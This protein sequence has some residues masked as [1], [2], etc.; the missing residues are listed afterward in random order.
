LLRTEGSVVLI[1]DG[2]YGY[3]YGLVC[4]GKDIAFFDVTSAKQLP[5]EK[6][7][8]HP[9]FLRLPVALPSMRRAEWQKIG[10][11]ELTGFH[12]EFAQYR[13]EPVGSSPM[14][15][16][17]ATGL[18]TEAPEDAL[19]GLELMSVWDAEYHIHPILRFHFHGVETPLVDM[20]TAKLG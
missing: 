15:Y 14:L 19:D 16:D 13:H 20:I 1:P 8:K 17:N 10:Q 3:Y 2:D 9:T 12:N 11:V 6:V 7:V 18:S 5:A 4:K